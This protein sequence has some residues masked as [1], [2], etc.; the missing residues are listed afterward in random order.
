[1]PVL[2]RREVGGRRAGGV[3]MGAPQI[4]DGPPPQTTGRERILPAASRRERN[5]LAR[6][7][8]S[9]LEV[10]RVEK[11]HGGG[12]RRGVGATA[13]GCNDPVDRSSAGRNGSSIRRAFED[14]GGVRPAT[15][16]RAERHLS[17]LEREEI[18][19]G[20][21]AGDSLRVRCRSRVA[22]C[23]EAR[24]ALGGSLSSQRILTVASRP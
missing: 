9:R 14:A 19:R 24:L 20:V 11:V 5:T 2:G 18:S 15:R 7:V 21:A 1:M 13:G 16:R 17:F 12:D 22:W 8:M 10:W 4:G 6:V 23:T 3:V